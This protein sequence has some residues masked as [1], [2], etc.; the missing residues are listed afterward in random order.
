MVSFTDLGTISQNGP[1]QFRVQYAMNV[2]AINIYNEV[3]TTQGHVARVAF[4]EKVL[5][6]NYSIQSVCLAVL[7][8]AT[9]AAEANVAT[10][11]AN[12]GFGIPDG[13]IQFS[14]NAIWNALA[15][16]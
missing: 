8:N 13:D 2:A 10:S 5:A 1:F 16:A 7:T 12:G 3:P 6:G 14:V 15:G 4:A 9:I 11:P